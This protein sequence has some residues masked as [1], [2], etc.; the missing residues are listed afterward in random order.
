MQSTR[1]FAIILLLFH[2]SVQLA[3]LETGNE[4][5]MRV[6]ADGV[7]GVTGRCRLLILPIPGDPPNTS[8]TLFQCEVSFDNVEWRIVV[9]EIVDYFDPRESP[10]FQMPL[11]AIRGN[12]ALLCVQRGYY[13]EF[14]D[15]DC[16]RSHSRTLKE[17]QQAV[18]A[19]RER[20]RIALLNAQKNAQKTGRT[21]E[22]DLGVK[23][24]PVNKGPCQPHLREAYPGPEFQRC[25]HARLKR[26][27]GFARLPS[28]VMLSRN[29]HWVVAMTM[30][31]E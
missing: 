4:Q 19:S 20:A 3:A 1:L 11:L 31:K 5:K 6:K 2:S 24:I 28:R 26:M 17:W 7:Q 23:L 25:V 15:V 22:K 30:G 10:I 18:L 14:R 27:N 21:V 13:T 16:S 9:D 8:L 29:I 12:Q